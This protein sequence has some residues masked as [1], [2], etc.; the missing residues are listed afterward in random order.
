MVLDVQPPRIT[1]QPRNTDVTTGQ[2]FNLTCVSSGDP[3]PLITWTKDGIILLNSSHVFIGSDVI[4]VS[5]S[6][7]NDSGL[8]TCIAINLAGEASHGANVLVSDQT[9]KY[10][11][12]PALFY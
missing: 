2:S 6:V 8:Y 10:T 9:G 5:S 1:I 7:K 4:V 12:H 3:T 11:L